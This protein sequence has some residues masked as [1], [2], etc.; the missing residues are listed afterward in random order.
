MSI[1]GK[2]LAVLNI[3]GVGGLIYL[4]SVTYAKRRAWEYANFRHDLIVDGL[5]ID[6]KD[7]D[8]EGKPLV[9]HFADKA[10]DDT[11]LKAILGGSPVKTQREE[12]ERVKGLLDAKLAETDT[13][14]RAKNMLLADIVMPL[15]GMPRRK[16]LYVDREFYLSMKTQLGDD[17][18]FEAFK[19]ALADAFPI[20]ATA[21]RFKGK[22]QDNREI[23]TSFEKAY[24]QALNELP[25][26]DKWKLA[27]A[28]LNKMPKGVSW[29]AAAAAGDAAA[30]D[31]ETKLKAEPD[32]LKEYDNAR[33]DAFVAR[34]E[35]LAEF[36]PT[37]KAIKK[38]AM[39]DKERISQ[40]KQAAFN[41]AKGDAAGLPKPRD[42]A[43][44]AF[45]QAIRKDDN[46]KT[47]PAFVDQIL[48]DALEDVK[49]DLTN[50]YTQAYEEA[51]NGKFTDSNTSQEL[52]RDRR[53]Q[54]IY[55][56]L[57][58]A[59]EVLNPEDFAAFRDEKESGKSMVDR[60]S[61]KRFVNV[62]GIESA[63]RAVNNQ[64]E[65]LARLVADVNGQIISERGAF[66]IR[67]NEIVLALWCRAEEVDRLALR[68][69]DI[70]KQANDQ[71]L[72]ADGERDRVEKYVVDLT[73]SRDKTNAEM[74]KLTDLT[75]GLNQVRIA[76]R[77]AIRAERPQP[78]PHSR[79]GNRGAVPPRE[80]GGEGPVGA[81]QE[82]EPGGPVTIFLPAP[83]GGEGPGER[84]RGRHGVRPLTPTPLPRG[85]RAL[86]VTR[87]GQHDEVRQV[88]RVLQPGRQPQPDDLGY[89]SIP[90]ADRLDGQRGQ[91]RQA[92]RRTRR[93]DRP[94]EGGVVS[95]A[96]Q[97][98]QLAR[99]PPEATCGRRAAAR[100]PALVRRRAGQ[101]GEGP[102]PEP[103]RPA[104]KSAAGAAPRNRARQ[105]R[106]AGPRRRR[107][108]RRELSQRDPDQDE[109]GP[110]LGHDRRRRDGQAEA[111][112]A[113]AGRATSTTCA[114]TRSSTATRLPCRRVFWPPARVTA[115]GSKTTSRPS[116][117]CSGR[118]ASTPGSRT[119][120]RSAK[121]S[122]PNT[123][124][125]SRRWSTPP[126]HRHS[127][128]SV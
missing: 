101:A 78:A 86:N 76:I 30:T 36:D 52:V 59:L 19:R 2:I 45:L 60:P 32:V 107:Q 9:R 33:A 27:E 125:S 96:H 108:P 4:S 71:K 79:P 111:R 80:G 23:R 95:N 18:R 49:T 69:A 54:A 62:V 89:E 70:A 11:T 63:V 57:F 75:A 85:A 7:S 14:I 25:G 97:R 66:R 117:A 90:H 68:L 5:P 100:H 128:W 109:A 121:G 6:D 74:Q 16:D 53:R 46:T 55:R 104:G 127:L 50:R 61:Y 48:T 113:P 8:K 1:L 87:R 58:A 22:S 116:R 103:G 72:I 81:R 42:A 34:A 41:K 44:L 64:E 47:V 105:G 102:G 3:L 10:A 115:R 98:A 67:H 31:V 38:K 17:K 83:L 119:R 84:G 112:R 99:V 20:A 118:P 13:N 12:V 106:R 51:S 24:Q 122:W 126:R 73:Q 88:P 123:I 39:D 94:C 77:D 120:S 21:V 56:F 65:T 43:A 93:A 29:D 92:G 35:F 37:N 40:Q 28:F 114:R 26:E 91:G 124:P 110:R 15:V 82:K